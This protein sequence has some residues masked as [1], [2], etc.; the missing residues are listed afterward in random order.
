MIVKT[1]TTY[2][3]VIERDEKKIIGECHDVLVDLTDEMKRFNCRTLESSYNDCPETFSY[4]Q[5]ISVIDF[6]SRFYDAHINEMY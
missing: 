5:I 1:R 4:E 2:D 6:L 3:V